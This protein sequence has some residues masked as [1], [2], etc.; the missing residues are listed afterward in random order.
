MKLIFILFI[1]LYLSSCSFDNKSGIW[2]NENLNLK[3]KENFTEFETLIS[4][5]ESF[6]E[7]IKL[8]KNFNFNSLEINRNSNWSDIFYNENNN[9]ENLS[10]DNKNN[11]LLKSKK[12][13]RNEIKEFF[14]F[15]KGNTIISDVAGNI[16]VYSLKIGRAHV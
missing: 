5:K 10:Y 12:L 6:Y 2:I 1:F 7:I 13:S 4:S 9:S 8:K 15:N 3:K 14:L 11:L 16:I